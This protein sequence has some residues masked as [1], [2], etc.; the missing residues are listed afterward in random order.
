MR[1]FYPCGTLDSMK[2]TINIA[3]DLPDGIE[4]PTISINNE[5]DVIAVSDSDKSM[6]AP[7]IE[8]P[9]SQEESPKRV[10]SKRKAKKALATR[11]CPNCGKE[12]KPTR[13]NH[14]YDDKKCKDAFSR[15]KKVS[16]DLV[17]DEFID[18]RKS[19]NKTNDTSTYTVPPLPKDSNYQ[20]R[21]NDA[22]N[23]TPRILGKHGVPKLDHL[24]PAMPL[25]NDSL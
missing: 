17:G 16:Q 6:A 13:A 5:S 4:K 20:D 24:K 9:V 11:S 12:F 2:L 23:R 10:N 8:K 15:K 22:K 7:V 14:L 3:I 1:F 25:N 19:R 18:S 21:L